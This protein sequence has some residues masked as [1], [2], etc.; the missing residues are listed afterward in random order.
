MSDWLKH[1][2]ARRFDQRVAI[3]TG[4][5]RGI[6]R[7]YAVSL[8]REG[9]KICIADIRS[10]EETVKEITSHGG[11]AISVEADVSDEEAVSRLAKTAAAEFGGIDYLVNNAA[12]YGDR[13]PWD[14]LT[15][16]IDYWN[17]TLAVNLTSVLLCTRAVVPY[18]V[19]RGGGAIVNQS[20]GAAF[21]PPGGTAAYATTK[22]GVISLT[23]Y[24]AQALGSKKIRV[25][26]VAP[27]LTYT[28]AYQKQVVDRG[29]EPDLVAQLPLGR[30][31][32]PADQAAAVLYLLSDDASY[33]TGQVLSV[34][35]GMTMRA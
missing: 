4:A 13:V 23:F 7:E 32:S 10:G 29:L 30:R 24:F 18:M 11:S 12:I 28:D 25:N 9:A 8:A 20:S 33:V 35:G 6:G 14:A 27:G 3:V 5:A 17:K 19:E 2:A 26:A 15:G 21:F 31:G 1:P 22:M 34:N 16:P